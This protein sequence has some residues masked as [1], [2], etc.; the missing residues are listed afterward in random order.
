VRAVHPAE[1]ERYESLASLTG[2]SA[3]DLKKRFSEPSFSVGNVGIASGGSPTVIPSRVKSSVSFRLVPDQDLDTIVDSIVRFV[4]AS[5]ARLGST[6][7]ISIDV[8]HRANWWLGD[9]SSAE[10]LLMEKCVGEVWGVPTE[11][12]LRIREGGVSP[13]SERSVH[14]GQ[15]LTY[16]LSL[17]RAVDPEHTVP[18]E[19]V[20]G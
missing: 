14:V 3:D 17:S 12:V 15:R 19:G 7:A 6:N 2:R 8:P 10:Y 9:L 4:R 13:A 20:F 5:Y 1:Q 18:R 16:L 11:D